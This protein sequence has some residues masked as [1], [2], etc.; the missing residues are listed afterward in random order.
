MKTVAFNGSPNKNGNT[1]HA[2]Q[3]VLDVLAQ[4]GIETE[5][6]HVGNKAIRGCLACGQC[7]K[8]RNERCIQDDEV[9]EWIQKMKTADGILIGSPVH[10]S[11]IGGTM[12]SFLD[13]AFYVTGVNGGMLRHKVGAAV[14]AVRRS[15]GI[16]TFNQLNTF[17]N[18]A[19]MLV[20][21]AN[22]WNVIHGTRPGEVVKDDE[23]QQI[24]RVL[25]RNM[26]WM[27]KLVE[28]GRGAV[29]PPAAEKKVYMNFIR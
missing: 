26:A 3:M 19:E 21:S 23:G 10:F 25:G 9:N 28:H 2:L 6:V 16:P 15:G 4:E 5:M 13:R 7:I 18:Y 8:H 20:P 1:F 11:A 24:M 29:E 17:L 27:M 12:K 14:V 22:Y